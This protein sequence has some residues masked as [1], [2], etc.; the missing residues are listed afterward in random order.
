MGMIRTLRLAALLLTLVA[1]GPRS[2]LAAETEWPVIQAGRTGFHW[3]F[4]LRFNPDPVPPGGVIANEARWSEPPQSGSVIWSLRGG[5]QADG[6]H[7]R[8]LPG[9]Q[10]GGGTRA[11]DRAAPDLSNARRRR[12]DPYPP[13]ALRQAHRGEAQAQPR[14]E[15]YRHPPAEISARFSEREAG[16]GLSSGAG[17]RSSCVTRSPE[18]PPCGRRTGRGGPPERPPPPTP[19]VPVARAALLEKTGVSRMLKNSQAAQKGPDAR[20]RPMTAR[21]AYSL[22][23]ERAGEGANEA[24]GPF[25]GAC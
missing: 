18:S 3:S 8:H 5:E 14:R 20:R 21:E 23:V 25:S 16:R 6:A 19:P 7:L 11:G 2:I 9:G 10:Q 17:E 24:D 13:A 4:S 1:L 15:S 12:G 22:Y